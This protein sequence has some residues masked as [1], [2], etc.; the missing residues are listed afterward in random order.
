MP[1]PKKEPSKEKKKDV[2][3]KKMGNVPVKS[4]AKS[5]VNSIKK[6]D[7]NTPSKTVRYDLYVGDTTVNFTGKNTAA[8]AINGQIPAPTLHFTEGD[9]ALIY[10]HNL[11]K[12]ATSMHWHG[13]IVP[14]QYDGVSY[15]TTAPIL[16]NTTHLFTFP[17]VQNG[18]YWYH[19]HDL[20]E[21]IGLYGA[22][23]IDK[24]D[25][26]PM[27][28]AADKLPDEVVVLSEF[29][30]ENPSEIN[31][32]LHTAT[33]WYSIK[34][35][36]TQSYG[37]ALL[38]GYFG[39]K[40]LSDWKR[41]LPMDVADI[42]YDRFLINGQVSPKKSGYKKGDKVRIRLINSGSSAY[43]WVQYA[44]GKMTII[45]ND[46]KDV[47]P[48]E[49][50]RFIVGNGETY[51]FTVIIPEDM[52]YELK[53][54]PEDRTKF[55]S[56]YLGNGMEMTVP[57]MPKL[58]YFEGMKMMNA[59]MDINGNMMDMGMK[60][61][62]QK[63]DMNSVMYPE[64]TGNKM[65]GMKGM[66]HGN[67]KGMNHDN[68]KGMKMDTMKMKDKEV[69]GMDKMSG[70]N[71]G[72]KPMESTPSVS[73][74]ILTLN[75]AMLRSTQKTTLPNAPTKEI[76]F[77][78]TGNMNR[79]VW[80]MDNKT[81]SETDEIL[82]KQ[83]E[84]VRII[85]YNGSMMRHPMHL[86]GHFFRVLNG[87]G[88]YAPLKHSVDIMPM[89]TDTL[90]FA[91]TESG[92]WFFHCH[93][94]YHMAAGMGRIFSYENSPPNPEVPDAKAAMHIMHKAHNPY[95][96]MA[97]IGLESNGSDGLLN[98]SNAR[99]I[100]QTLWHLGLNDR[101]GY[102]SETTFGRY[103]GKM[104][105]LLPYVGFDYH[106]KKFNPTEDKNI[107]GNEDTN[108]FGQKSNKNNRK[109]AVLGIAYTLPMFLV[110]DAR[111]DSDGKFRFQL[112]RE[113]IA[114]TNRLR[115]NFMLNTDREYMLGGRYILTKYFS[116]SSHYDSDMGFG[117]GLTIIY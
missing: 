117:G 25:N 109:A 91:A 61:S 92:D 2:D 89:E 6:N 108:M 70:M 51:D 87:Q 97:K 95:Y 23:I 20:T 77:E 82:I 4:G 73:S 49:V 35:R 36:S 41:I 99:W 101:K 84:N 80:T 8:M 18:T 13:L 24:K 57:E 55:A 22:F 46:G 74:D 33:D 66:N 14:N 88:D 27:S 56:L 63:M 50:D 34:K 52:A 103:I 96:T 69:K 83:G 64:I 62:T 68:M 110:A 94:L 113:D 71:H 76:R 107:F 3:N 60:M 105:W 86:H 65:S 1:M 93:I 85:L 72:N 12:T 116:L 43:F 79:Y 75:Y 48:V 111:V 19:S 115:L 106:F 58:K 47:E 59:M 39:T 28:R 17:I 42:Y 15:L 9:T 102:E 30:N 32:R 38:K 5:S 7:A 53:A 45:A 16:P 10:V 44:G 31:R 40:L 26:A 11:L 37:E 98:R 114:L 81:M 100:F 21:Q 78:L 90:E 112:G 67:M 54:T 104:Q 29:T